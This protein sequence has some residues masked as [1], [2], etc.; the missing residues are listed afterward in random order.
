[1]KFLSASSVGK[2]SADR[3]MTR[4]AGAIARVEGI[5]GESDL[6]VVLRS[7]YAIPDYPARVAKELRDA[8]II[9]NLP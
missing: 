7:D 3:F 6:G 5:D 8:D 1:L 2:T 4:L 9:P